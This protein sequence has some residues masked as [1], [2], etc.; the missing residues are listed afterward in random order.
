MGTDFLGNI[1]YK[2]E[3]MRQVRRRLPAGFTL[4]ELLV[5]I[6]IIA[7]LAGMLLPALA[8]AKAKAQSIK[9]I[10]N[11]KQIGIA[12]KLYADENGDYFPVHSGWGDVGGKFW[13]NANVSGNAA[14]YGGRTAETNRPLN[15]FAGAVEVF[16]CPWDQGD[17]L[18]PQVKTCWAGWGNSYLPEWAADAFRVRRV[19]GDSRPSA[20]GTPFATSIRESEIARSPVNKII[21]ADWVWHANRPTSSAKTAW[22]TLRGKR[23][24]NVLFG[25]SHVENF[26]FPPQMDSWI[27][28]PP[29][30]SFLWW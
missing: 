14:D 25:D 2:P 26:R 17:A 1:D 13:T 7:I 29:D 20:K 12:Y 11:Q 6:A 24:V 22:H 28:T 30:P 4:I 15:R 8:R 9:C 23:F 18:N 27:S 16:H 19:T 10:S 3:M 21:Q 5:V